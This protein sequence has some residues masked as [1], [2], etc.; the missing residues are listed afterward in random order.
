MLIN[1]Y[2]LPLFAIAVAA[3]PQVKSPAKSPATSPGDNG[4]MGGLFGIG[5]DS[6]LGGSSGSHSPTKEQLTSDY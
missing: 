3:I 6:A 5:G 1:S 4:K 2:L